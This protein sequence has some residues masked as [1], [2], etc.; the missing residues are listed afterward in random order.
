MSVTR[1][2]DYLKYSSF[3]RCSRENSKQQP[4]EARPFLT[5]R[6]KLF[7]EALVLLAGLFILFELLYS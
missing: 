1:D 3:T 6:K 2:L 7:L 5:S 4:V